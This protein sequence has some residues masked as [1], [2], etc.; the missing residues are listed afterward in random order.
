MWGS[1]LFLGVRYVCGGAVGVVAFTAAISAVS[2]YGR[3]RQ[4][5][6]ETIAIA[7]V[8]LL[9][10][11]G[12]WPDEEYQKGLSERF[13]SEQRKPPFW[14]LPTLGAT[15]ACL[16]LLGA[17]AAF[18][19]LARADSTSQLEADLAATRSQLT[20]EQIV[21]AQLASIL[22]QNADNPVQCQVNIQQQARAVAVSQPPG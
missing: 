11:G 14:L 16:L 9:V 3:E 22:C 19:L 13:K 10:A 17:A 2:F 4:L 7:V 18:V 8:S 21:S 6:G 15:V 1:S 5:D 20:T 12:L